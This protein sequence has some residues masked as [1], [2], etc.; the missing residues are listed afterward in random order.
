MKFR[1]QILES[2][3]STAEVA[4]LTG[5]TPRQVDYWDRQG[6]LKPSLQSARGYGSARRYSFSDLVRLR[7]AGRLRAAGFGLR[8]VRRCVETLRRLDPSRAGID[9][10]RLL[11]GGGRVVWVRGDDELVDLLHGGQLL[12]V[13][14]VGETVR[15][16]ARAVERLASQ[17]PGEGLFDVPAESAPAGGRRYDG[18]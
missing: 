12:L 1:R 11:I 18:R 2:S 17:P 3:F 4:R 5:L 14:P 16:T 7:L 6:F 15:E 10:A 8:E 13:F 9:E